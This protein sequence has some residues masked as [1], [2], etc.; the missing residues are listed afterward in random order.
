ML[1]AV[2]IGCDAAA[3]LGP[4]R[5]WVSWC[6]QLAVHPRTIARLAAAEDDTALAFPTVTQPEPYIHFDRDAAGRIA[7]VRH[8]REGDVMPALGQSDIGLFS[9][10]PETARRELPEFA[11][12]APR[13]A[14]TGERNFLPFIPWLAARHTVVTIA[15]VDAIEAVGINTPAELDRVARHLRDRPA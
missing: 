15:A 5:V 14:A 6:D 2:L 13:G 4:R 9:L 8:R 10:A 11:A 3:S 1:D 7:G 12:A